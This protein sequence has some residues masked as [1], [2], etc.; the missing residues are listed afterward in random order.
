MTQSIFIVDE[1]R[2]TEVGEVI[3]FKN[4]KIAESYIAA[5][6]AKEVIEEKEAKPKKKK[7]PK[8]E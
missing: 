6:F 1:R 2:M 7:Q 5:G 3:E 4:A 8:G